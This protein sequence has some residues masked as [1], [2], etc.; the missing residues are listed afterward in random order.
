VLIVSL[1]ALILA[2]ESESYTVLFA[3]L[4]SVVAL[5]LLTGLVTATASGIYRMTL[6]RQAAERG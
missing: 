3:T 5:W 1:V 4:G 6:Y 2:A